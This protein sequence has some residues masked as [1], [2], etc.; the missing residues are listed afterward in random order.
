MKS[1]H[2]TNQLTDLRARAEGIAQGQRLELDDLSPEEVE[3]L[4]H[5]LQIHQIEL[6]LQNQELRQMQQ[7]LAASQRR[8]ADLYHA[9]P[10]GY[11]TL[12]ASDAVVTETNLTGAVMLETE[13]DHLVGRPFT[14]FIVPADQDAFYLYGR[15]LA[16]Q[17]SSTSQTCEIKLITARGVEFYANLEGVGSKN[18]A[19]NLYRLMVS[20]ITERKQAEQER[21]HLIEN[22]DAFAHTVAHDLK[23]ALA[24]VIGFA[25]ILAYE[26][27]TLAKDDMQYYGEHI[28]QGG[29][30]MQRIIKALLLLA[31]VQEMGEIPIIPLDMGEVVDTAVQRLDFELKKHHAQVNI[32]GRDAWPLALGYAPWVEEVWT[33]YISN[34]AKY[35]AKAGETSHIEIGATVHSDYVRFWVREYGPGIALEDQEKLFAKFSRVHDM[36]IEGEG[37]GLSIVR[38]IVEKLGGQVGVES[39]VGAG[40]TFSFTLPL[41]GA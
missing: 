5:E 9:A 38:R 8:Y 3:N 4:L 31:S 14:D 35:G 27:N 40:S 34:A 32:L 11:F 28:A 19:G 18:D 22:L 2:S 36:D 6:E 24:S 7:D 10:A 15:K 33:N 29:Y 21:D 23:S 26:S 12:N 20:D 17:T 13:Q 25:E 39:A 37:L 16:R 41:A 30:R 1:K